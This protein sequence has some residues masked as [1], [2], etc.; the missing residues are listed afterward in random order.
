MKCFTKVVLLGS[1]KNNSPEIHWSASAPQE[2]VNVWND[3]PCAW[4]WLLWY[5]R[6]VVSSPSLWNDSKS[7]D[8]IVSLNPEPP[9]AFAWNLNIE[10]SVPGCKSTNLNL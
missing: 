6:P 5:E 7:V 1:N 3:V 2:F 8:V 10:P 9:A 4:S